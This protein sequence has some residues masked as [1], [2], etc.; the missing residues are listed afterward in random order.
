MRDYK[1][2][3]ELIKKEALGKSKEN[4]Q[5]SEILEYFGRRPVY[6]QHR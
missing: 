3:V 5:G 2:T 4:A 1:I 6:C